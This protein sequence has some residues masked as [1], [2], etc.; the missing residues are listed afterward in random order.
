MIRDVSAFDRT[1]LAKGEAPD[2]GIVFK[3]C[4]MLNGPRF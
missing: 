2:A 4:R 1:A 3:K